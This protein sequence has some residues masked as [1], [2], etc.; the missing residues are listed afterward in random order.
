V[1]SK[2]SFYKNQIIRINKT[3]HK[4]IWQ[5]KFIKDIKEDDYLYFEQIL[6]ELRLKTEALLDKLEREHPKIRNYEFKP[7]DLKNVPYYFLE[8]KE[9]GNVVYGRYFV[10]HPFVDLTLIDSVLLL[11]SIINRA[12]EILEYKLPPIEEAVK[13]RI[14]N[15]DFILREDWNYEIEVETPIDWLKSW[16]T[17]MF[18]ID[19]SVKHR[20]IMF[21][22][23]FGLAKN[24]FAGYEWV[25]LTEEEIARRKGNLPQRLRTLRYDPNDLIVV[26][27]IESDKPN[28][29]LWRVYFGNIRNRINIER[30]D[31]KSIIA[32]AKSLGYS[33]KKI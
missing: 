1:V 13:I 8:W 28:R 23:T 2:T 14:G 31:I 15:F 20:A 10:E 33:V 30:L 22:Q 21:M 7:K 9:D 26:E 32:K 24:Y 12:Y 5:L 25:N 16:Q 6:D 19:Y 18:G 11:I 4:V 29:R 17:D 3:I 27:E